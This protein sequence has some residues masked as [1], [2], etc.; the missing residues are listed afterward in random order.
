[1]DLIV[2]FE[3]RSAKSRREIVL[4]FEKKKQRKII[5]SLYH[6]DEYLLNKKYNMWLLSKLDEYILHVGFLPNLEI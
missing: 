4:N 2:S 5:A 6:D 3:S 1:M